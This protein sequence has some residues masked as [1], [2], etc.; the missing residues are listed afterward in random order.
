[1]REGNTGGAN[2]RRCDYAGVFLHMFAHKVLQGA[3]E[4]QDGLLYTVS[5]TK[6]AFSEFGDLTD[7]AVQVWGPRVHF[8]L[9]F[10]FG[11][12]FSFIRK[13]LCRCFII[14]T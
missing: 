9:S 8:S 3:F 11:D 10:F 4:T 2:S 14:L 6:C 7:T 12:C 5:G 1:M 13:L